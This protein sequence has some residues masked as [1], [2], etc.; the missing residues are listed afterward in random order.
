[1]ASISTTSPT[2]QARDLDDRIFKNYQ[3]D[4]WL[5]DVVMRRS[6]IELM[7]ID[8]YW[9][10]FDLRIFYKFGVLVLDVSTL[11]RGFHPAEVEN[12]GGDPYRVAEKWGQPIKSLDDYLDLIDRLCS[13]SKAAGAMS[14]NDDSTAYVRTLQFDRVPKA[15]AARIFGR[16]RAQLSPPEIKS[17]GDFITWYL[18]GLSAKYEMPF[19]V[20]H[21]RWQPSGLEPGI[22]A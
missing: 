12:L 6:N 4:K 19:P 22:A 18:A 9:E 10:K 13:E 11:S 2:A 1:M 17:F 15:E 3:N 14:L 7:F 16:T 21:R 20:P 8:P 5:N